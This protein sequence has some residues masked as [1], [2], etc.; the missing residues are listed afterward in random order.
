VRQAAA[1][2]RVQ[3][4][5]AA[6][7]PAQMPTS[8]QVPAAQV[9]AAKVPAAQVR[10]AQARLRCAVVQRQQR[11]RRELQQVAY[12]MV[13]PKRQLARARLRTYAALTWS[14]APQQRQGAGSSPCPIQSQP[15]VS[16]ASQTSHHQAQPSKEQ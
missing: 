13:R 6:R 14:G 2:A 16:P 12:I 11:R 1:A 15:L 9:P 7:G 3:P 4:G 10:A 8:A 5:M